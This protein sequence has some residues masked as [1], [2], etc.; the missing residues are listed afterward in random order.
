MPPRHAHPH[1]PSLPGNRWVVAAA[2]L[3]GLLQLVLAL[4]LASTS[5]AD[6]P[7]TATWDGG[8][9]SVRWQDAT[10]WSGDRVPRAADVAC[11]PA[12]ASVR[13]ELGGTVAGLGGEGTLTIHSGVLNVTGPSSIGRLVVEGGF[14]T[15][16]GDM[17]VDTLTQSAG[18]LGGS[19][20][21]SAG[22]LTWSG[23]SEEGVGSTFVRDAAS[24][25]A[26]THSLAGDRDLEIGQDATLGWD[27][28]NFEIRDSARLVN[29]G[30]VDIRGDQDLTGAGGGEIDN[31]A[32]ATLRKSAGSAETF[33]A[34]PVRNEGT[35]E[36][37]TGTLNVHSGVESTGT[38]HVADAATLR[39]DG[40]GEARLLED[41]HTATEG[42]GRVL[43]AGIAAVAG[44]YT[45]RT[46]IDATSAVVAFHG[47]VTVPRLEMRRGV[48]QGEG[49]IVTQDLDWTGGMML[50]AGATELVA[51]G[52]G[53]VVSGPARHDLQQRRLSIAPGATARVAEQSI[54]LGDGARLE[55]S[56]RIELADGTRLDQ[57]C[58]GASP[59]V[60]NLAGA[61]LTS[62]GPG[63]SSL[64]PPFTNDGTVAASAGTLAFS[65]VT[66]LAGGTLTGGTWLVSARLELPSQVLRNAARLTLDGAGAVVWDSLGRAGGLRALD[67]NR[68][69]GELTVDN[70]ASVPVSGDLGNAGTLRIGRDASVGAA[71]RFEQTAGTTTLLSSGS[72]LTSSTAP[73]RVS[74]GVL[75]GVG[76]VA[77][78]LVNAGEVRP[79]LSPG[80][81]TVSGDYE[82]TGAGTL[83]I[84]I[85]GTAQPARDL[86]DISGAARLAGTLRVKTLP[87][88]LPAPLDEFDVLHHASVTGAFDQ[89]EG[90]DV[91]ATHHYSPPDYEPAATWLRS[92]PTITVAISD[93]TVDEGAGQ[94]VL[95]VRISA[96]SRNRTGAYVRT[97]D[98]SAVAPGDYTSFEG[99]VIIEPGET[100]GRLSIPI[101]DDGVDEPDETFDVQL[102]ETF[103]GDRTATVTI[104]DNDEPKPDPAPVPDPDPTPDP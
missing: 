32:G 16:D 73:A 65:S 97:V 49:T 63:R 36:V 24:L 95:E 89:V 85:G 94:A 17:S 58:G 104:A 72:R 20:T 8:A 68:P 61:V 19:G 37:G 18:L 81:L 64:T 5:A 90:R 23:G 91:D 67:A 39:L 100:V 11:I 53:L 48:L 56:G 98:R 45:A 84:E 93:V 14:A 87:P 92:A 42:S 101:A 30:L 12:G 41:S 88:F 21:V 22:S 102:S 74:G 43:F 27:A 4:A 82:Q 62:D 57:C 69:G 44:D 33:V 7:C 103:E 52:P 51:G 3:A 83:E 13:Q 26:G 76:T 78:G 25:V 79:G 40:G 54:V 99:P 10:N 55:N 29:S 59:L 86:L 31:L 6:D 75:S 77:G 60:H 80:T 71:G 38:M 46:V 34:N 66:N 47:S 70:G 28:G 35:V 9:H 96:P 15:L 2:V 50:G 1:N